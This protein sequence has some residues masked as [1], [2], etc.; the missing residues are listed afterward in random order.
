MGGR[1]KNPGGG[2]DEQHGREGDGLIR[3]LSAA[4]AEGSLRERVGC[5][6]LR[7]HGPDLSAIG[8]GRC[9]GRV[10]ARFRVQ[11]SAPSKHWLGPVVYPSKVGVPQ[12]RDRHK[13][14]IVRLPSL[15]QVDM[16]ERGRRGHSFCNGCKIRS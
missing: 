6:V 7:R 15:Q 1:L 16:E 8:S 14:N 2:E 9:R 5:C 10:G 12:D 13:G 11:I 3:K 4:G